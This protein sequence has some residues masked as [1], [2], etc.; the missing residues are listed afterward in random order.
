MI[1][2]GLIILIPRSHP[3]RKDDKYSKKWKNVSL[4]RTE[5][6]YR[7]GVRSSEKREKFITQYQNSFLERMRFRLAFLLEFWILPLLSDLNHLLLIDR[8]D[9]W[10]ALATLPM[11][12]TIIGGKLRWEQNKPTTYFKYLSIAS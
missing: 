11:E 9:E 7:D 8:T 12:P 3:K 4:N 2:E 10:D 6:Q 5:L 1:I